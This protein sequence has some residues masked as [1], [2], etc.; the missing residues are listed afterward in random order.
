MKKQKTVFWKTHPLLKAIMVLAGFF[1]MLSLSFYC[2]LEVPILGPIFWTFVFFY[3]GIGIYFFGCLYG[4]WLDRSCHLKA[5]SFCLVLLILIVI[6]SIGYFF[7]YVYPDWMRNGY[8]VWKNINKSIYLVYVQI[9]SVIGGFILSKI[10]SYINKKM[11]Q[12]G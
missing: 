6:V 9:L 2:P 3:I 5:L 4:I 10:I 8:I 12:G 1:F 7:L 11:K